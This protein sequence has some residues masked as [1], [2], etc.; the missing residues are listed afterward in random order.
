[1]MK[2][3]PICTITKLIAVCSVILA[4]ETAYNNHAFAQTSDLDDLF[5]ELQNEDP[6]GYKKVEEKIWT[7]WRKSGS[8]DV[9]FLLERGM[10]AMS[11]GN[12]VES[13]QYFTAAI[14]EAP[15]FSEAWN[16]RATVF[17]LMENYI[18][19]VADI[20]QTLHLNPRHFGAL[21]G[22]GMIFERTKRPKQALE[23]Y[24]KLLDVHPHSKNAQDAVIRLTQQLKGT[25]L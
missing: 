3:Y 19:S 4:F 10:D 7:E 12:F 17:F 2:F 25:S 11:N 20:Q 22:L 9:D 16:M 15:N 23:V 14:K 18:F 1:M 6:K 5:L 21:G 8:I 13:V 24:K